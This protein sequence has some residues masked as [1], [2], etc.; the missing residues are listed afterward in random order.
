MHF[1]LVDDYKKLGFSKDLLSLW[2]GKMTLDFGLN[3]FG[4]FLPIFLYQE[5]GSIHAVIAWWVSI[6]FG[7]F[8]LVPWTARVMN[9]IGLKTSLII[10][11]VLRIPYLLAFYKLPE[12]P[13]KYAILSAFFLI[14]IRSFFWL[15]FQT[16]SAKFSSK[17]NRGKQFSVIWSAASFLSIIAP[18][19]GGFVLDRWDFGT[20]ALIALF[21][22]IFSLIPFAFLPTVKEE[23]TWTYKETFKYL[24]HPFNRRMVVA[25]MSDGAV[26]TI[27]GLF[28]PLFIFSIL[29]EQFKALGLLT[30]A[31]LLLGLILRLFIGNLL[32]RIKKTKLVKI[33]TVLNSSAWLIKIA[34]GTAMQVFLSSLYHTLAS[35]VLRTSIETLVYE[36][37][38]D[39]GHYIDEYTLIKEMAIHAGKVLSL[40]VIAI[41]LVFFPLQAAFI[42]A[43][44]L[45]WFVM[46]LK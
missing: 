8:F 13:V 45:A 31:I 10:G 7:Y 1:H 44:I 19:I 23:V 38:A 33:G 12:D 21:V 11:V 32:D 27:N 25:Y 9:I 29:D 34:V 46:L 20:L 28:W 22:C 41:L 5:L 24:V 4:L 40:I 16:D 26:T 14:A 43:A 17:K 3:I 6:S 2:A 35:I 37:A 36:K 42:V 30:G 15:P 39:R 18:V